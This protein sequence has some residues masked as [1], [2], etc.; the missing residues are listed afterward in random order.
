LDT[1]RL[2]NAFQYFLKL[3][4]KKIRDFAKRVETIEKNLDKELK[5]VIREHVDVLIDLNTAQL[6]QGIRSD[7]NSVGK[8]ANKDYAN[9]KRTLN[10]RGVVD[11]K[12][13]G[14]FHESFY[15]RK[16]DFPIVIDAKDKKRNDLVNKYGE[17]IF[18]LTAINKKVFAIGYVKEG[19]LKYYRKVLHVR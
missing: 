3:H 7:G 2:R 5:R 9:F 6:M 4:M 10:P 17:Q 19:L 11:L 14:A 18:G 15:V 16:T 8:Y 13:T 12:L 1:G